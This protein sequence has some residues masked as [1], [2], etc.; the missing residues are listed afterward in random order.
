MRMMLG[1]EIQ[2]R[3]RTDGAEIV[4]L[5]ER[6][7]HVDAL[8]ARERWHVEMMRLGHCPMMGM[9]LELEEPTQGEPHHQ[10]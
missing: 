9:M 7:E 3:E 6:P 8:R 10:E 1:A 5:A 4:M 2:V